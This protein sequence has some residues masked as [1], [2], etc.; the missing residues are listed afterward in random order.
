MIPL[1]RLAAL[2]ISGTL[3]EWFPGWQITHSS[4]GMWHAE[5]RSPDGQHSHYVITCTAAQL[6]E[7]LWAVTGN[8]Q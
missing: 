6:A 7:R 3:A 8:G 5:W 4:Q 2:A 1:P